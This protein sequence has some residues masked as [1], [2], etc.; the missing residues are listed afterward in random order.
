MYSDWF[1]ISWN[2]SQNSACTCWNTRNDKC[3]ASLRTLDYF[4]VKFELISSI[5]I[6][7]CDCAYLLKFKSAGVGSIISMT[8]STF[9]SWSMSISFWSLIFI[10]IWRNHNLNRIKIEIWRK[11]RTLTNFWLDN[12]LFCCK[13][14]HFE[15][16]SKLLIVFFWPKLS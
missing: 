4:L 11:L 5:E 9:S 1:A 15:K 6:W 16:L 12:M 3:I 2:S 14:Q 10:Y 8:S 7:M 13:L